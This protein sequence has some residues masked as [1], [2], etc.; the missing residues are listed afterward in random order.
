M[1]NL[2]NIN[3]KFLVT[4]GGNVLIGQTASVAGI[5]QVGSGSGTTADVVV[6][7]SGLALLQLK[8]TG[9]NKTYNIELGRNATAGDL[10]F[11]STSGE[12]VRFTEDGNVGIGTDAP[13]AKLEVKSATTAYNSEIG[14]III[15][16]A[17]TPAK[18][19]VSGID[20]SLGTYGSGYIQG[21]YSGTNILPLLLNPMGGNVG[22]G[23][24]SPDAKLEVSDGVGVARISGTT[25]SSAA[26]QKSSSL[27]FW[28]ADPSAASGSSGARVRAEIFT[29]Y[30]TPTGSISSL[31]FATGNGTVG[32][33]TNRMRIDSS[34]NST[35]AGDVKI[36]EATNKGQLF[37]GTANTDYEIK[38]GGNYGYLSLNA[39]ILRF[40]TGGTERMRISSVG[41]VT[42]NTTAVADAMC[43]IAGNSSNYALNLY[44]DALY[45][46]NYRYQRFRSGSNIAGGI[47]SSNQTSVVYSTSSDYRM[48]KNIKPLE[49]GLDRLCKLKPVKF[50]WKLN[51]ETTEGFIAHEVQDVFPDA[52]SGEKDGEDMQGMDYGRITPLLVAAIQELKADNDSLKARIETLENN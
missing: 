26:G 37:F 41:R 35:F 42:I 5:L 25:G 13:D 49:D 36:A 7:S 21:V 23:T 6:S 43:T 19:L 52:I 2:S 27:E 14:G 47:E 32:G 15:S 1:A 28:S 9:I 10:T 30:E 31:N 8:D 34:G 46:S 20:T 40:D 44:A 11:R 45:S 22:I 39:P 4:T 3:N 18:K 24:N 48:K 38:G 50:D 12:K 17:T 33:L 29:N 16:D 51:D